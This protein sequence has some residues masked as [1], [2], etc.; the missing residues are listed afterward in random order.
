[1]NYKKIIYLGF[2][3]LFITTAPL[4]LVSIFSPASNP[5]GLGII[6]YFGAPVALLILLIGVIM[7]IKNRIKNNSNNKK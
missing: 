1:M 6:F 5:I 2:T 3:L 7:A 4:V